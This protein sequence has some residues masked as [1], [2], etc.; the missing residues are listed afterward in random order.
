MDFFRRQGLHRQFVSPLPEE[1]GFKTHRLSRSLCCLPLVVLTMAVAMAAP[2]ELLAQNA[3]G[4]KPVYDLAYHFAKGE[5]VH[6]R[7]VNRATVTTTMQGTTQT[8][9]TRSESI[10]SW[11]ILDVSPEGDFTFVHTVDQV[12]M[13]NQVGA[14]APVEYDSTT[15]AKPPA[16]FEQVASSVGVPLTE[17]R[18]N[19]YGKILS[20]I[21][22]QAQVGQTEDMPI[23]FPLPGKPVAVGQTWVDPHDVVVILDGG[24]TR[25]IKT[26]QRYELKG[27]ATGVA[28]IAVDYQI[29]TPT[30]DP[31][32]EAQLVQKLSSGVIKFDIEAGRLLSQQRDV[33]KRVVGMSGA[34]SSMKYQMRLTEELQKETPKVAELPVLPARP[35]LSAGPTGPARPP[36]VESGATRN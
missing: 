18:V 29:L 33:D 14:R 36:V 31:K 35:D 30:S 11:R 25:V 32:I 23:A 22:K 21:D 24:A 3:G 26:R 27:V 15:D 9:E 8:A 5:T 28:T 13:T 17:F 10:K 16:G 19:R 1:E 34:A 12:K 4:A 2:A 6:W 20:R 7:V